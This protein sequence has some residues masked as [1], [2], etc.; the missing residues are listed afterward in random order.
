VGAKMLGDYL[1]ELEKVTVLSPD[2]EQRLWLAYKDHGDVSCRQQ[3]I[4]SY[5][6]LVIKIAREINSQPDMIMDIIQE[7]T[8]GLIEAI[9][10]YD[11]LKGVAF[12]IYARYRIKGR[13]LNLFQVKGGPTMLSLDEAWDRQEESTLLSTLPDETAESVEA[14]VESSFVRYK[15]NEAVKRLNDKERNVIKSVYMHDKE[16]V[17]VA[18]EMAISISY[19]HKLQKRALRRMR[20]MLARFASDLL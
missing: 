18:R 20:G 13:M 15:V 14:Q 10:K 1:K 9:E 2:E 17:T 6:P 5:Q 12:S 3:L 16:A 11:H 19:V 7:G 4:E 8:V